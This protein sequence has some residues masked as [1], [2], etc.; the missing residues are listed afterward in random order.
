MSNL[1]PILALLAVLTLV[2]GHGYLKAPYQR[3]SVWREG[4]NSED[5]NYNDM[6][7]NCGGAGKQHGQNGGKCGTCG[8]AYDGVREH[9]LGGKYGTGYISPNAVYIQGQVM[10][11]VV[12]ITANH[13]GWFEFRICEA[14]DNNT[15]VTQSC[16]DQHLLTLDNGGTQYN[17]AGNVKDDIS[18]GVH[19]PPD[20]SCDHCVL[21]WWWETGNSHTNKE[22]FVNCA[23]VA[24]RA[25]GTRPTPSPTT[26][27]TTTAAATTTP[28]ISTT[29]LPPITTCYPG[30]SRV[31]RWVAA[32]TPS[33]QDQ[34]DA[35]CV[36]MSQAPDANFEK[37]CRCDCEWS[38]VPVDCG[39]IPRTWERIP[40]PDPFCA[41]N[42]G[43]CPTSH[44]RC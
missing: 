27:T 13:K 42:C 17:L 44:C 35:V 7:V 34:L 43:L 25:T 4:D 11:V 21:Q 3:S 12:D 14:V 24:I 28:V 19:L 33:V 8:D 6:E 36:G 2:R 16:L 41:A 1:Y 29:T 18:I 37:N 31:C 26:T 15:P 39:G 30:Q 38:T 5:K 32:S 23:D 40:N 20:L 10:P 22:T 9:E